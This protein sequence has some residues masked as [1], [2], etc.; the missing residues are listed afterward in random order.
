MK[1][2]FLLLAATSLLCSS[3]LARAQQSFSSREDFHEG[4]SYGALAFNK[5]ATTQN[6]NRY[7]YRNF[8]MVGNGPIAL[9]DQSGY[10][11]LLNHYN[12]PNPPKQYQYTFAITKWFGDNSPPS[13]TAYPGS[14]TPTDNSRSWEYPDYCLRKLSNLTKV[15]IETSSSEGPEFHHVFSFQL[16]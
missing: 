5:Q 7:V 11:F 8:I 10:C 14:Y 9:P 12:S 1:K 3:S 6:E 13:T 15:Q 2:C 16:Q 4:T